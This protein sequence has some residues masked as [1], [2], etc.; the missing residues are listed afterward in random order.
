[1]AEDKYLLN[2]PGRG[3]GPLAGIRV[4]DLTSVLMGPYATQIMGDLGADVIKV[5]G[6]TGDTTRHLPPGP[7]DGRGAMFMNV[8]RGKRS[9]ALDLK[10]EV[11]RAAL[12]K[13]AETADVFVHSMR[14]G[15]IRR[16]GLDYAALKAANPDIIY[17]NLWGFGQKGPL[18]DK[19]AYD[20]IVQAR[21][22]I[23]ELQGRQSGGGP[24]YLA[25]V[26]ADKVTGITAVYAII[27]ALFGRERTGKGQEV[28]VPMFE[29]LTSFTM[30]EHLTGALFDPPMGPTGY[31]RLLSP[32]RRPY[33]TKD[34]H[35]AVM[36]Y[37]DRQWASFFDAVGNPD[38]STKPCFASL[39]SRTKNIDEVLGHLAETLLTR[40]TAEW[41]ALFETA[42]LPSGP[43]SSVD[44]LFEDEHLKAV[45]YWHE[46][47]TPDGRIRAP[48]VPTGFSE[49]PGA[50]GE[51]GPRLGDHGSDILRAAG[52][53]NAEIAALVKSGA[54][55][56]PEG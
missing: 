29:T 38:W 37:T 43:V 20:D 7:E 27:A 56:T 33:R 26:V 36:V 44:D 54:L 48:G 32:D 46:Q 25:H 30:V 9:L 19:P 28:E 34:G 15:A 4:L 52:M 2:G 8:N 11:A 13:L 42:Q 50:V 49:T 24:R 23:A 16:L 41:L 51:P 17:A 3:Q 53:D 35:I 22:G 40:T 6:P 10:Q 14:P 45:G 47:D 1:M 21:A 5:E 12:L 39:S 18:A 31:V 55:I